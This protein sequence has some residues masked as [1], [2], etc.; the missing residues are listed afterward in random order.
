MS[1]DEKSRLKDWEL[2]KKD[3]E[4]K[5]NKSWRQTLQIHKGDVLEIKYKFEEEL[6]CLYKKRLF[7]EARIYEQELYIIRLIIMLSDI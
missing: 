6:L 2:K 4:D 5:Q 3:F 7:Y 1:E